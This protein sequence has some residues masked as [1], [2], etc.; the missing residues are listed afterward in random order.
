MELVHVCPKPNSSKR[1]SLQNLAKNSQEQFLMN[2]T[3]L[4]IR[5]TPLQP[6][7]LRLKILSIASA[8]IVLLRGTRLTSPISW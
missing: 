4:C 1:L 3:V 8:A 7:C 5:R 6:L 2:F